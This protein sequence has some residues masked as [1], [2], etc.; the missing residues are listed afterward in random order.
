MKLAI[1]LLAALNI[2]LLAAWTGMFGPLVGDSRDPDRMARQVRPEL[3]RV[4]RGG[5]AAQPQ[6]IPPPRADAVAESPAAAT[7]TST[8][9]TPAATV[10]APASSSTSTP[11][12]SP[13][14][15]SAS[16][17]PPITPPAPAAVSAAAAGPTPESAPASPAAAQVCIEW[18][19]FAEADVQ[20]AS[21]A[22]EQVGV[23]VEP[24]RRLASSGSFLVLVP[25][26]A[27]LAAAQ[28]R[29]SELRQAGVD[30]YVIPDGPYRWGLS[31]GVFRKEQGARASQQQ[32]RQRGV[33]DAQVAARGSVRWMLQ[34]RGI[35]A[36]S[37]EQR[38]ALSAGFPGRAF[39]SCAA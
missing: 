15:A 19:P 5:A 33:A 34:L 31:L 23:R 27:D 14:A 38:S 6:A 26:A 29:L 24:L 30:A 35:T 13:V 1:I 37:A 16:T 18:G 4:V 25:P 39:Q 3:L 22:A 32:L 11:A 9:A 36:L 28:Q 20:R 17:Q 21:A 7:A 10:P 2:T 12:S 8:E